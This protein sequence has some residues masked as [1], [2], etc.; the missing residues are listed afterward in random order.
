MPTHDVIEYDLDVLQTMNEQDLLIQLIARKDLERPKR[1]RQI[2]LR[3][4]ETIFR[5]QLEDTIAQLDALKLGDFA[6]QVRKL[7]EENFVIAV[8]SAA[9]EEVIAA[10]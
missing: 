8:E 7:Y 5:E 3:D 2:Q 10:S 6:D 9:I 1:E 4:L